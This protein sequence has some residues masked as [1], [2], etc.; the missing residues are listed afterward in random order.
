M[1]HKNVDTCT[2]IKVDAIGISKLV[3]VQGVFKLKGDKMDPPEMYLHPSIK[4]RIGSG[5]AEEN[6]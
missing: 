4:A 3:Q 2:A 5:T 6:H 1:Y